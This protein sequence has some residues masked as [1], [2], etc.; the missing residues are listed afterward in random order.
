MT[1][2]HV[3]VVSYTPPPILCSLWQLTP[4]PPFFFSFLEYK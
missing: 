4:P 1:N 2:M 3:D